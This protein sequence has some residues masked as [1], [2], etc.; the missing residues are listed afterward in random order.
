MDHVVANPQCTGLL[1]QLLPIARLLAAQLQAEREVAAAAKAGVCIQQRLVA[2]V[3]IRR[4]RVVQ[5]WLFHCNRRLRGINRRRGESGLNGYDF[6]RGNVAS[7]D[8]CAHASTR[9][10]RLSALPG[11][12]E[13]VNARPG[14]SDRRRKIGEGSTNAANRERS[15]R[16]R[17]SLAWGRLIAAGINNVGLDPRQFPL[18]KPGAK[19]RERF[20]ASSENDPHIAHGKT[21]RFSPK[22]RNCRAL[23]WCPSRKISSSSAFT[24]DRWASNSFRYVSAPPICPGR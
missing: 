1:L 2:L 8:N 10:P 16:M 20:H 15:A 21:T 14:N 11:D 6:F 24:V 7:L 17:S 22:S 13:R 23:S 9:K 3:G 5:I 18:H 19:R 4:R 12:A